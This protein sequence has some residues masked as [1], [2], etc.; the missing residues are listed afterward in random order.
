[1]L[2]QEQFLEAVGDISVAKLLKAYANGVKGQ[3]GK[4][5]K[6]ARQELMEALQDLGVV[7]TSDSSQYLLRDRSQSLG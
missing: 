2:T 3:K 5:M 7:T 4:T 1:M 6:G